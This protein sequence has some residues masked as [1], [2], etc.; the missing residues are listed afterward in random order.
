MRHWGLALGVAALCGVF[1]SGCGAKAGLRDWGWGP[2]VPPTDGGV[3]DGTLPDARVDAGSD[4]EIDCGRHDRYT[5]PRRP[6]A[7]EATVMSTGMV[8]TS[9]WTLV[10][11]P[12]M[13]MPTF[14]GGAT[15]AGLTPD[16]IGDYNLHFAATDNRGHSGTCDVVVHSVVGPPIAICPEDELVTGPNIPLLVTGDGYDDEG[17]VDW[18]WSITN[19]P[20]GAVPSLAPIN[21]PETTFTSGTPGQYVLQL[22]VADADMASSTCE[23]RVRVNTP[24]TV[25]CPGPIDAP[26][27]QPVSVTAT[28]TDD[29]MITGTTWEMTSR[30]ASSMSDVEPREGFTTTTTPDRVGAY[31]L[32]FTATDSDGLSSS[33]DVIVNGTPT[34]PDAICPDVI[35]TTPLSTVE[36]AGGG[37]DDGTIVGYA[38]RLVEQPAG[39]A[40]AQPT[41]PNEQRARLSIDVAG[42]YRARLTVT[43]ND[44]QV[45]TCTTLVRAISQEGLRVEMFWNAPDHSCKN[46]SEL[47][48]CDP[49][50]VDLHLINSSAAGW[51][52]DA[53]CFYANCK[54]GSERVFWG[55]GGP[56]DDPHLDFDTTNGFG[57]ENTNIDRPVADVYRVGVDFFG[58]NGPVTTADVVVNIYC[59]AGTTA[60]IAT[61]GPV[62]LNAGGFG[63]E[64]NDFWRVADVSVAAGTCVVRGLEGPDGRPNIA[65]SGTTMSMR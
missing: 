64:G 24:P 47:P 12:A 54:T 21:A 40:A 2:Y 25:T 11:S 44:G 22:R 56:E 10:T 60:P 51:F 46:H 23:A 57:P 38:W 16:M 18:A 20:A 27:R 1:V 14:T 35:M 8:S 13:S 61:F 32:H 9:S 3:M 37:V 36:L 59:G 34:A 7:I 28:A 31:T 17:V 43:D 26:T 33:C 48:D 49:S 5:S 41:P 15:A 30:P 42:E 6:I 62:R 19:A 50:D 53:D 29:T 55:T 4:F 65:P 58:A 63:G 45:G 52:G 39:S